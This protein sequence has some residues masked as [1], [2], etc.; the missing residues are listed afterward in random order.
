MVKFTFYK[1]I[2]VKI[3]IFVC[4]LLFAII[5]YVDFKFLFHFEEG[6]K[7]VSILF[8]HKTNCI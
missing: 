2:A 6:T 1:R 8:F 3:I 4:C 5:N 7:R